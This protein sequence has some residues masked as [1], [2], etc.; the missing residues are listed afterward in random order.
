M[1]I[2]V[3]AQDAAP[4]RRLGMQPLVGCKDA[5]MVFGCSKCKVVPH[6]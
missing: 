1:G 5:L 4:T 6:F 3:D 2:W